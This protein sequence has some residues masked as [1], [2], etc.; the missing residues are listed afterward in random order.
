MH[1]ILYEELD[2]NILVYELKVEVCYMYMKDNK[3]Q[4]KVLVKDSQVKLF[5]RMK[6]KVSVENLLPLFVTKVKRH[7]ILRPTLPTIPPRSIVGTF[8]PEADSEVDLNEQAPTNIDED[9]ADNTFDEFDAPFYNNDPVVDLNKDGDVKLQVDEV[10]E[11]PTLRLKLPLRNYKVFEC[12]HN[13]YIC[14]EIWN[15][16]D[17]KR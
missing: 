14:F 17:W 15:N 13:L 11:V 4:L 3:I 9:M 12:L 1:E 6:A 16:I 8:V 5:L 10:V 2:I 7:V